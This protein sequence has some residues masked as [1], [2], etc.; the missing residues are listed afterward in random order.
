MHSLLINDLKKS[1]FGEMA[2]ISKEQQGQTL[3]GGEET[4]VIF[5]GPKP[6]KLIPIL[7]NWPVIAE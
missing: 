6:P 1:S 2:K 5:I 4:T 7:S 3:G